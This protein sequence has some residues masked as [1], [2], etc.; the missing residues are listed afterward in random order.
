MNPLDEIYKGLSSQITV[1]EQ[2][3]EQEVVNVEVEVEPEIEEQ[4]EV[5]NE[6]EEV[7]VDEVATEDKEE[8]SWDSEV[9]ETEKE[10]V[11]EEA[12]FLDIAKEFGLEEVKTKDQFVTGLKDKI[13]KLE[14]REF[15]VEKVLEDVPES[16]AEA[17]QIAKEGGDFLEYLKVGSVDYSVYSDKEL[18]ANSL[19]NYFLDEEGK[20]NESELSEYIDSMPEKQVQIEADKV[21]K[22]LDIAKQQTKDRI[23]ASANLKKEKRFNEISNAVN[24]IESVS[25]YKLTPKHK[26]DILKDFKEDNVIKSLFYE[27]GKF[28]PKKAIETYFKVLYWDK[29][30]DYRKSKARNETKKEIIRTMSNVEVSSNGKEVQATAKADPLSSWVKNLKKV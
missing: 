26:N 2:E 30:E 7:T 9:V 16:L 11:K 13:K 4:E 6:K 12:P 29:I 18:L 24:S 19:A 15:E 5:V 23:I 28:E 1:E 27:S 8:D 21:R 17:V 22:S 14:S 20:V 3:V 10:P 25:G